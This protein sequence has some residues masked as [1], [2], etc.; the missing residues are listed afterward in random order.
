MQ[1]IRAAI[2]RLRESG[3]EQAVIVTD[4][5][6]CINA[7]PDI[8]DTC[9]QPPG[10]WT[11][12]HDRCLLGKGS[13]DSHNWVCDTKDLGLAS[14]YAQVGGPKSFACY[15]KN[16]QY[17][18]GGA[19][20]QEAIV[21]VLLIELAQ[22]NEKD[23]NV[24]YHIR[25]RKNSVNITTRIPVFELEAKAGDLFDHP[26]SC[27][28]LVQAID[29]KGKVVGEPKPGSVVNA[30]T[31]MVSLQI[32]AVVPVPVKMAE[33]FEGEFTLKI[34]DPATRAQLAELALQTDYMV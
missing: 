1:N 10:E 4:H 9:Q 16:N 5:G 26:E 11:V 22:K 25:Y 30:A 23:T 32:G 19:S 6:F 31:G 24:T 29:K 21:P 28:V 3:F 18:H 14:D 27:E 13:K 33:D 34:F 7:A 20:L 12:L 8:G 15:S 2:H 17:F